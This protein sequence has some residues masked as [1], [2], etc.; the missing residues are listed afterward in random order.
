MLSVTAS[1]SDWLVGDGT[2]EAVRRGDT[3]TTLFG[4]STA[5]PVLPVSPPDECWVPQDADDPLCTEYT[6]TGRV[7]FV[8]QHQYGGFVVVDAE[9]VPFVAALQPQQLLHVDQWVRVTGSLIIDP[10]YWYMNVG[11]DELTDWGERR[12]H[13]D[14]IWGAPRA[15][16]DPTD[17]QR[18][19]VGDFRDID[20]IPEGY[21]NE[22]LGTMPLFHL[23]LTVEA[24]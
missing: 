12:C 11:D 6:V 10:Y 14:R 7:K 1:L 23:R 8:E 22:G 18:L 5:A 21:G 17:P 16:A 4:V 20:A 3:L 13:V 15:A 19:V 2:V 9:P 24:L